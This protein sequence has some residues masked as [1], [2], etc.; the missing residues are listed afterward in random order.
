MHIEQHKIT[1][2]LSEQESVHLQQCAQCRDLLD[3]LT[4]L[5]QAADE[6]PLITPPP[7][8]WQQI[9]ASMAQPQVIATPATVTQLSV[10]Q[11]SPW[12]SLG[13]MAATV[14]LSAFGWLM[15]SNYQLQGQLEQVLQ[16]NQTLEL[17][18]DQQH[19]PDF[20]QAEL[21]QQVRHLEKALEQTD[22][23]AQKLKLLTQRQQLVADLLEA[24]NEVQHEFSI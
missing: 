16:V 11:V 1:Q 13:A 9:K 3:T 2:P 14:M 5:R 10:W 22:S 8:S 17:Q 24:Q 6:L 15:W 23:K 19:I 4:Q 20:Q 18:L 21:I 7:Q 12:Q